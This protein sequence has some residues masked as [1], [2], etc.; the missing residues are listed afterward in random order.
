LID[1]QFFDSLEDA[2]AFCEKHAQALSLEPKYS[3]VRGGVAATLEM[4]LFFTAFA[5][6]LGRRSATN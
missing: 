2:Q 4:V 3:E 5:W 6:N 1:F